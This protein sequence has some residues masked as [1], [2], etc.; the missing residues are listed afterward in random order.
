MIQCE[1]RNTRFTETATS[2]YQVLR[3]RMRDRIVQLYAQSVESS[4]RIA[5]NFYEMEKEL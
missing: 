4:Y 5:L 3:A 1:T 2:Q